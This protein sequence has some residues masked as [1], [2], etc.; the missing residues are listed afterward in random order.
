MTTKG[1]F[2]KAFAVAVPFFVFHLVPILG[3]ADPV[4]SYDAGFVTGQI[5]S[6]HVIAA[7]ITGLL[8]KFALKNVSWL[9]TALMYF[10]VVMPV[11]GLQYLGGS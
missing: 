3:N 1:P 11:I 6:N 7:I 5:M 2:F 9:K 8:G 10:A 4:T